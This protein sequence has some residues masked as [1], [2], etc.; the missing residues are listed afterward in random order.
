MDCRI[1]SIKQPEP[2]DQQ[3]L[4]ISLDEDMDGPVAVMFYK[5]HP[6]DSDH[7]HIPLNKAEALKLAVWIIQNLKDL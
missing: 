7:H 2:Y 1:L 5:A 3:I 6:L 4:D